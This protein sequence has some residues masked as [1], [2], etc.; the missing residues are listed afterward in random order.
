VLHWS[1]LNEEEVPFEN[2]EKSSHGVVDDH[3]P[4][5]PNDQS[6]DDFRWD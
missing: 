2:N 4:P 6:D 1:S 5:F 3:L